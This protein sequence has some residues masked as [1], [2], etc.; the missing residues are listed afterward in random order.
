MIWIRRNPYVEPY[1]NRSQAI[2][3]FHCS[4]R[5]GTH[6]PCAERLGIQQPP[7][8]QLIKS[9]ER[10]LGVQLLRRKPR[11]VELTEAGRAF[12]NNA[13]ATLAQ[14]DRT[15]ETVRRTARGE[16]GRISVGYS[17]STAFHPLVP[18]IIREFRN[19]L[20]SVIVT[21]TEGFPDD[22]TERMRGDEIDIAFIGTSISDPE[23]VLVNL[24]LDEAMVVALPTGHALARQKTL[25]LKALAGE[26]F[27]LFGRPGGA[28]TSQSHAVVAACQDAGFEP[29][30]GPAVPHISSRL[31]LVAAGLGIAVVAAS[32]RRM[33]IEGVVYRPLK[34]AGRLKVPLNLV[35]RR[36]DSS[37]AVQQFV[38]LA[39]RVAATFRG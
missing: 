33:N 26:T 35:T 13:R 24:L 14:F 11:G 28:L 3:V 9:I 21:L 2:Q 10:E 23:G 7:L 18:R 22:L 34:S 25:T 12:L 19:A 6:N 39:K 36:S 15:F 20:S 17:G 38:K 4:R 16:E 29:H 1:G 32:L 37:A 31:N 8:S 5:G 30:L 27:I